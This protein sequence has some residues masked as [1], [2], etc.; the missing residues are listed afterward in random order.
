MMKSFS[1]LLASLAHAVGAVFAQQQDHSAHHPTAA[2]K[3]A[4]MED[5]VVRKIDKDAK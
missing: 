3:A 1:M 5:G 2:S 4:D